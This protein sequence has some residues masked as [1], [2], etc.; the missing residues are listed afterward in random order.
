[1][2]ERGF[3]KDYYKINEISKLY[4]IGADSLRYY[5]RIGV[6]KPHRGDN[7]Y[8]LYSLKDIYKLSIIKDLRQLGM[9]MKQ[10]KEYLDDQNIE[11][12][13]ALLREEQELIR[14]QM[15]ELLETKC[16][17]ERRMEQIASFSK[18]QE[19]EFVIKEFGDRPCL[20]LNTD[21]T[22]D[23][24]MDFAIKKLHQKHESR[25]RDFGSQSMGAVIFSE[26]IEKDVFGLFHSVFFILDQGEKKWDFILEE[27]R[28][29]SFCYRG[30]Y[31]RSPMWV[32]QALDYAEKQNYKVSGEILELYQIDNRYT[33]R[34]EEFLTEI[35]VRITEG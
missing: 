13:V 2:E 1:M 6:L 8:R 19:G 9:S 12:T 14:K 16:S 28:Y 27:G 21:I 15:E 30:D 5:E 4:G 34:P 11:N 3:M 20:Q 18:V 7:D 26:D 32:K 25:I 29:L 33:I 23:E 24:E 17:I 22:R 31:R 35:Q 10:I